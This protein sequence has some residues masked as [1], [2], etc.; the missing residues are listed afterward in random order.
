MLSRTLGT[1]GLVL[2]LTLA[3]SR[4][5]HAEDYSQLSTP[6]LH[7]KIDNRPLGAP[8]AV[9]VVGG[10]SLIVGGYMALYGLSFDATCQLS[11]TACSS[12]STVAIGGVMAAAGAVATTVGIVWLVNWEGTRRDAQNELSRRNVVSLGGAPLVLPGG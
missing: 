4:P 1:L 9:T 7:A 12:G 11:G 6:E 3:A 10:L 8:I 5:A 2:P